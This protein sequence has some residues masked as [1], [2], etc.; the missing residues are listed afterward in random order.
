MRSLDETDVTVRSVVEYFPLN[1]E[2]AHISQSGS[3]ISTSL[4]NDA[5]GA[6]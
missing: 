2:L 4:V 1:I 5:K 6:C 3:N